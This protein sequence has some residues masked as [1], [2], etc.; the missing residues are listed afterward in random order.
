[1]KR[2]GKACFMYFFG[3]RLTAE[4]DYD[5]SFFFTPFMNYR[6]VY[7]EAEFTMLWIRLCPISDSKPSKQGRDAMISRL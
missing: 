1:M 6:Y 3:S 7:G 2:E 5:L 4:M